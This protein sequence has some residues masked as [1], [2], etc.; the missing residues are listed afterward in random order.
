VRA[1]RIGKRPHPVFDATGAML[2]GARWNSPGRPVIYAA[3]T[4]ALTVLEMLAHAQIGR[5][6][7]GLRV[8]EI[9]IPGDVAVETLDE[10][11][12]PGWADADYGASQ[13]FGDR[14]GGNILYAGR[15]GRGGTWEGRGRLRYAGPPE[16][17]PA[18]LPACLGAPQRALEGALG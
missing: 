10:E 2:Y 4:F 15:A 7:P 3:T 12:L 13:K 8:V 18:P 6:P 17:A 14:F 1:W 9:D 5:A 11:A 16:A